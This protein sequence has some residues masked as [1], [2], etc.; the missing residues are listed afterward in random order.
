MTKTHCGQYQ[1]RRVTFSFE[2]I[3]GY[4]PFK[5]AP[6]AAPSQTFLTHRLL[7]SSNTTNFFVRLF[8]LETNDTRNQSKHY[9]TFNGGPHIRQEYP[10]NLSILIS[11]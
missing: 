2:M 1:A 11:A 3:L 4:A 9:A 6:R 8:L 7:F 5:L 10:V